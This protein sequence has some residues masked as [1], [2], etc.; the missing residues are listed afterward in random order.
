MQPIYFILNDFM[1]L[2]IFLVSWGPLHNNI[3]IVIQIT[4]NL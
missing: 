4:V 1:P 2:L 3:V